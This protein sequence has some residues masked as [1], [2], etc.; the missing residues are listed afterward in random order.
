LAPTPVV[1]MKIMVINPNTSISM[2]EH[3][4]RE[5]N[6]VK[7]KETELLVT[8]P[9]VGPVVIE[10]S[11][12]EALSVPPT[13][14]LVR[15][16]NRKGFDA[17]IIAC[18]SDPGLMASR[19]ISEILVL[20][21]HEVSLHIAAMLGS[22]YT[23]LTT[24]AKRVPHKIE[25]V[26]R[27]RMAGALASVRALE[28]TTAETDSDPEKTIERILQVSRLAANQDGAEVIILGCAGMAGYA[29]R[30]TKELGL[31][32]IDPS[33]VTL[34]ICEGMT[35]AGL[36]HCKRA[37]YSYPSVHEYKGMKAE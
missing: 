11:Y 3:L 14:E 28:L 9:D 12:D 26:H 21:I 22:R 19:E 32:V 29:E 24:T 4:R 31:T 17:V 7:R 23:I 20:G 25:E 37:L 2:T 16:A 15:E 34:K 1:P 35:E 13:L 8:C 36:K 10:S 6:H 27:Y 18:F 33:L 30:V 5:L